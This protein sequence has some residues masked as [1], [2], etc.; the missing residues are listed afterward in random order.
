LWAFAPGKTAADD[1]MG[2][3][4]L[5]VPGSKTVEC[6]A[7]IALPFFNVYNIAIA[8][9]LIGLIYWVISAKTMKSSGKRRRK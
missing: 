8:V 6:P 3:E 5:C 7:Q 9:V 4:A 1:T 2:L